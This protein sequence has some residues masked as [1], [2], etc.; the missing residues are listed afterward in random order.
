MLTLKQDTML[1][2]IPS[3]WSVK[4]LRD[5][6]SMNAP[7]DWGYDGGPHMVQVI[8]STNLTN[9]RRLDLVDIALRALTPEKALRL[10]PCKGDILLER[11]GGG[12]G[13]PVGRIGFVEADIPNH[14][15]SNF[16]HLLRPIPDVIDPSFL[17][18]VLHRINR[19][20][21]ILRLEQQTTQI[22]NLHFRDYL[23]MA[24]P[25]PPP[26]EQAAIARI[27][28]AVDVAIERSRDACKVAQKL[29]NSL[30]V[31][32]L[33]VGVGPNGHIRN[34]SEHHGE[35]H[36]T[37][38]GRLPRSWRL[39]NV[40]AEFQIQNGITLNEAQRVRLPKWHYL[41]VANVQRDALALD[42]VQLLEASDVEVASRLLAEDDLLVVEGHANRLQIG[43]CA[44]VTPQAVGMT[45]QN[46][47]FR[48]RSN[49]AVLPAFGCLW[50]NSW[51]AQRYWNAM[52]A[53][54]SGLNTINQSMLKRL[55]I[56]VPPLD[57]QQQ[58]AEVVQA[59]KAKSRALEQKA[60]A[61]EQLKQSLLHDLL[62]GTVRVGD[63]C[64]AATRS[65]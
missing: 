62:T 15:F 49:G 16:L 19:T 23:T 34:S 8:R 58:I 39:S 3:N 36:S 7:G 51:Q 5:L 44:I 22:R 11:S 47:L 65:Y 31:E 43:R 60:Q 59:A 45:F 46:H 30:I 9:E 26:D 27:L 35:F 63:S 20:G 54:S 6:L 17:A 33:S 24:L 1:G 2:N 38:L 29:C 56:P 13:Q 61:L 10:E 14:A 12:P 48:L 52:C 21:R 40:K 50:L 42:E 55:R 25:V 57:E 64:L 18:W 41:R 28:D 4:P 32:L 53:T 37:A